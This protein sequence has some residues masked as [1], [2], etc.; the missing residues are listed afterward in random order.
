MRSVWVALLGVA[1]AVAT[2]A[3]QPSS[4]LHIIHIKWKLEATP[5][6]IKAAVDAAQQL[7]QRF[8]GIK[9]VWTRN[10]RY[11]GQERFN[12][13]IV[14]EFE[15]AEALRRYDGSAAQKWWYEFY[16]PLREDSRI[17]DLA[18]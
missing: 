16:L 8:P 1:M 12:Q 18:N 6:Q 4:V 9:R 2:A 13:A 17:D 10:L 11:Q 14:L 5:E 3:Q 7:P 15:N